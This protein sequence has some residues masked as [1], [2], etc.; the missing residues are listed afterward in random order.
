MTKV[1][2]NHSMRPCTRLIQGTNGYVATVSFLTILQSWDSWYVYEY[3]STCWI[4]SFDP[5][6][7]R[8]FNHCFGDIVP[9]NLDS[10]PGSHLVADQ[11]PLPEKRSRRLKQGLTEKSF[12]IITEW[13]AKAEENKGSIQQSNCRKLN[14]C[15]K[16]N[17]QIIFLTALWKVSHVSSEKSGPRSRVPEVEERLNI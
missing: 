13:N 14:R 1:I 8:C 10:S 7:V 2:I 16:L 11:D 6:R 3:M 12:I 17:P 9:F 15:W 5:P 4:G